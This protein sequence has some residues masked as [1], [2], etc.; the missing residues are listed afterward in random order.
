MDDDDK[1][2]K[3]ERLPVYKKPLVGIRGYPVSSYLSFKLF[4]KPHQYLNDYRIKKFMAVLKSEEFRKRVNAIGG[5]EL[6][7]PGEIVF[8]NEI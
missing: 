4:V 7:N 5:Y 3:F 8:M 2:H 1:T 6:E